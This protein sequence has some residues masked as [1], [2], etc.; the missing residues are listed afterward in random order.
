MYVID[1]KMLNDVSIGICIVLIKYIHFKLIFKLC[2]ILVKT[3]AAK[4]VST[5]H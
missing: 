4:N 1:F 3:I 2:T 5:R